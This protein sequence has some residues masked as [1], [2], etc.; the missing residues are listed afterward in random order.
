M[1]EKRLSI[2]SSIKEKLKSLDK[3]KE[4]EVEKVAETKNEFVEDFDYLPKFSNKD[5]AEASQDFP[6]ISNKTDDV[7]TITEQDSG[8]DFGQDDIEG[9]EQ[10]F[11][12]L[13]VENSK[14]K[15]NSPDSSEDEFDLDALIA[16]EDDLQAKTGLESNSANEKKANEGDDEIEDFDLD[17]NDEELETKEQQEGKET[18]DEDDSDSEVVDLDDKEEE[19]ED[20]DDLFAN[21]DEEDEHEEDED[22]LFADEDEEEEHEEE[23]GEH[24]AHEETE[25]K[26]EEEEHEEE[27]H[28]DEDDLFA[29]EDEEDEHEED[30]GEHEAHEETEEKHEEE[31]HEEE[32]HEDED[33]LFA[34]E[35]EEEEHDE[36]DEDEHDEDERDEDE[37]DEHDEDEGEHEAHDENEDEDKEELKQAGSLG[38]LTAETANLLKPA[39]KEQVENS[40]QKLQA[41]NQVAEN[42]DSILNDSSLQGTIHKIIE[43][44]I[45]TWLNNNLPLIVENIVASEIAKIIKK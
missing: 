16:E 22:E 3:K 11:N 27:E 29:D 39:V 2:L 14:N 38:G 31:E 15:P 37:E 7:D 33:D 5:S 4:V 19:H 30:E 21:E 18:E 28:E 32:E 12:E 6:N 26:H 25:E 1:S 20:E 10:E 43:N 41:V 13:S 8:E 44:K 34:D 35:D 23:E 9:Y 45:E 42:A 24:E 40:L 17:F 36:D